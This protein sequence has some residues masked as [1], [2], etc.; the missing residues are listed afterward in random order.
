ME[1]SLDLHKEGG[2]ENKQML[3]DLADL[4]PANKVMSK[5]EVEIY[6]FV[7]FLSCLAI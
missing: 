2:K 6:V 4:S 7:P 3:A 5:D 1:E